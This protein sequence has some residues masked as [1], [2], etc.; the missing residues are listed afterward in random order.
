MLGDLAVAQPT[1]IG[2]ERLEPFAG[3]RKAEASPVCVPMVR[4]SQLTRFPLVTTFSI[5]QCTCIE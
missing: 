2:A 3:C 1:D 5:V 4:T